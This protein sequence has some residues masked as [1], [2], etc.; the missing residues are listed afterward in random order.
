MDNKKRKE[1][2]MTEDVFKKTFWRSFPLQACFNFERM[3]N[4]GFAYMMIP[5]LK[6][7][8]PNKEDLKIALKRHLTIFNTTPAV[9][10]FIAGATIAMEEK[11]KNAKEKGE[12]A[13]E[14]S[15]NAVKTALMGPLAGIGD[16]FFWGTFRIIGAGI[17]ASLAAKGSIMGA[18]LFLL[19]YN[20]PHLIV[21]Y[22]GL[23]LGY[24]S[25][26]SF[27]ESL[28]KGGV[29]ALLTEVAKILGLVVVGSMCGSMV[30]LSTPLV[31][32]ISGAKIVFQEVFDGIIKGLLPLGFTWLLYK[33]LQKGFKT[34]TLLWG[35]LALGIIGAV[36]GIF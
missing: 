24:K 21:R 26:V 5:A 31:L 1:E 4:I 9:V 18:V 3:Q 33:L 16:S 28:S 27:L 7:L 17:G 12:E 6:K 34:T 32:K 15:I 20:I 36:A 25:G 13:D 35:I 23:K 19:I 10:T 29:I 14:E 30:S 11:I 22:Q 2:V 8:Y